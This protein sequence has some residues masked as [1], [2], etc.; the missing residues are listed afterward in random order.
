MN[1]TSN[2]LDFYKISTHYNHDIL[3]LFKIYLSMILLGI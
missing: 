1:L 3:K 2:I